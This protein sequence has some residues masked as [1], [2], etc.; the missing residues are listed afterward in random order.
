[1]SRAQ[2]EV[3]GICVPRRFAE[4]QK[5]AHTLEAQDFAVTSARQRKRKATQLQGCG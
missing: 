1:M 2:S 5:D 3:S 4:D